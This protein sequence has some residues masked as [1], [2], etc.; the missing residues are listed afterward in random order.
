MALSRL[1][2]GSTAFLGPGAGVVHPSRFV[3]QPLLMQGREL[4]LRQS[5]P[6][7]TLMAAAALVVVAGLP[8]LAARRSRRAGARS[9]GRRLQVLCQA[10]QPRVAVIG[11]GPAGLAAALALRKEAGLE[12]V[13]IFE[14]FSELRPGIGGGVQ[15]HAGAALL[16]GLGVNLDF[17]GK[18][19]RIK[20]RA[21]DGNVLLELDLKELVDRY[22]PF[23]DSLLFKSGELASST[24]MRDA[25]LKAMAEALPPGCIR[26]NRPLEDATLVKDGKAVELT[27]SGESQPLEFDLVVAADGIGSAARRTVTGDATKTAPRYTG[28]R[29]QYGVR[30]AGGRPAGTD[31]E[32][33]QWFGEGV[34]ALTA[35]YG[36]LG[37]QSYEMVASVFRDKS[38]VMENPDWTPAEVR[39]DCLERLLKAGHC[40]EVVRVV[41]G[42]DRFFELGVHE[43][44][45]GAGLWHRGRVVLVGDSAH[46]MP[47][48]LGQGAN[49]AVQ[50]AVCLARQLKEVDFASGNI[51]E[52]RL[53]GALSSYTSRRLVP[54]AFLGFE[55]LFLGQVETLPGPLGSM[56]RNNFFR[57]TSATGAAGLVFMNGAVSRI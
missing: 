41:E 13:E 18:L 56:F 48:F 21:N 50:D 2:P 32:A 9:S 12:N 6:D 52:D 34:Y 45:V 37:G 24:V 40:D 17:R 44:P 3:G 57:L 14:R 22:Q 31:E 8:V 11:A 47:P 15:L 42:C 36:G 27:F 10:A 53:Q 5:G 30:E 20:S 35:T 25:L 49:Q 29:I 38:P 54:V 4:R 19:R 26:F 16:E 43:R 55:S 28:I 1:Q 23:T 46:A 33:H 51:T 39:E 7:C